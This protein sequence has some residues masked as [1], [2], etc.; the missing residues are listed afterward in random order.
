MTTDCN[1]AVDGW[2][3]DQIQAA[4]S[5]GL[6]N[7]RAIGWWDLPADQRLQVA[8][9]E[10]CRLKT[11]AEHGDGQAQTFFRLFNRMMAPPWLPRAEVDEVS[12]PGRLA[13][14]T[15]YYNPAGYVTRR[16]NYDR[17]AQ[18]LEMQGVEL[19]TIELSFDGRFELPKGPRTFRV[20]GGR[21]HI[22]WQK[23]RLLTLL[24]ARLP[25]DIDKVAW[26]DCD[27]LFCNPTWPQMT[28]D[29]LEKVHVVQL[30]DEVEFLGRDVRPAK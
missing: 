18:G 1:K 17:F 7:L 28:C 29:A 4:E 2:L 30:F 15:S 26:I 22:M 25:A 3:L 8:A 23:E 21:R 11:A 12:L 5:Y 27:V 10:L 24:L 14:I 6:V 19:W 20:R 16:E 9:Y 13:A